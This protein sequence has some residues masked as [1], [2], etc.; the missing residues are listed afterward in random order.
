MLTILLDWHT[1]GPHHRPHRCPHRYCLLSPILPSHP[2]V[3]SLLFL[4][5]VWS[6]SLP[7]FSILSLPWFLVILMSTYMIFLW[8]WHWMTWIPLLYIILATPL[9]GHHMDFSSPFYSFGFKHLP[10]SPCPLCSACSSQYHPSNSPSIP[11]HLIVLMLM[12]KCTRR[13]K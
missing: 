12:L 4:S 7:V 13:W 9:C 2:S 10:C 5:D 11:S 1:H 3:H 6:W 8:P